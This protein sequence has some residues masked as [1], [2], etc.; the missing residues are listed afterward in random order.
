[1]SKS[2]T[3]WKQSIRAAV[4]HSLNQWAI[5]FDCDPFVDSVLGAVNA[6]SCHVMSCHVMSSVI[7]F[8]DSHVTPFTGGDAFLRHAETPRDQG[9]FYNFTILLFSED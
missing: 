5:G 4:E 2:T 3:E 6:M 1:M 8:S 7:R 9:Q